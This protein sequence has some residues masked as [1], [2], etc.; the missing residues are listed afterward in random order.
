MA[1]ERSCLL[2]I[3]GET[4]PNSFI[5]FMSFFIQILFQ[6]RHKHHI[7]RFYGDIHLLSFAQSNTLLRAACLLPTSVFCGSELPNTLT[8]NH[9]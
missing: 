5:D 9:N 2:Y 3:H 7:T 8:I 1:T 6:V 4:T